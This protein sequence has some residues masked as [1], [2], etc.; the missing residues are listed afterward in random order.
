MKKRIIT[1][2]ALLLMTMMFTGC[3][4]TLVSE[5]LKGEIIK[6]CTP[7][8]KEWFKENEPDCIV[9]SVNLFNFSRG[10]VCYDVITGSYT[11]DGKSFSYYLNVDTGE[12]GSEEYYDALVDGL[13]LYLEGIIPFEY[14]KMDYPVPAYLVMHGKVMSDENLQ[15]KRKEVKTYDIER[16]CSG[17][18]LKFDLDDVETEVKGFA[19]EDEFEIKLVVKNVE[20]IVNEEENYVFLREHNNWQLYLTENENEAEHWLVSY[21]DG[22]YQILMGLVDKNGDL[23]YEEYI[24]G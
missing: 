19:S 7:L 9:E 13:A 15:K 14:G 12:F 6:R 2:L 11:R 22:K 20:Y 24:P 8:T 3:D 10:A 5:E 1:I 23:Y 16:E 4:N 17:A 18:L 21:V